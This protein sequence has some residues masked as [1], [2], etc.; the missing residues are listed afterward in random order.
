[1][2]NPEDDR[3]EAF[4]ELYKLFSKSTKSPQKA[5][6]TYELSFESGDPILTLSEADRIL[7]EVFE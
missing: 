4:A 7:E 1:M 2:A 5:F 3:D 6:R